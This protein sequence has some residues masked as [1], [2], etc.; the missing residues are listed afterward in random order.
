MNV[1]TVDDFLMA[2]TLGHYKIL[3]QIGAGGMGVVYRAQDLNLGRQVALSPADRQ[4]RQRGSGRALRREARTAS[5]LNHPNICTIYG[6]D[7]PDGQLYLAWNCSTASRSIASCRDVPAIEGDARHRRAGGGRARRRAYRRHPASRH[8]AG[9]YFLTRRG[10]VKVL[11]FG[12]AK[13]SPEYSARGHFDARHETSRPNISRAWRDHRGHHRLH[14][15]RTGGGDE[16][17][18][19]P[20]CFL[21]CVLY[22]MATGRQVSRD[23]RPPSCLTAS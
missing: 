2:Q 9:Q 5:S 3:D 22:E 15:A 17:D 10:P 14:V 13:L 1:R 7:E 11:D 4:Y 20:I 18:P 12:L 21:R 19:E 23:T 6:F 8:Q 16:V